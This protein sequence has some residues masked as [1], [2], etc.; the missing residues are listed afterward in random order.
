MPFAIERDLKNTTAVER[1][2]NRLARSRPVLDAFS[3][4]LN[5]HCDRVLPKSDVYGVMNYWAYIQGCFF[6][7][8]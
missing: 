4:W 5:Y 1:Y 6:Y 8:H 7:S 2:K 3:A